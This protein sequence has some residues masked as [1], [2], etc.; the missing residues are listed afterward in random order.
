MSE[1]DNVLPFTGRDGIRISPPGNSDR[2]ILIVRPDGTK[3]RGSD[4]LPL[5]EVSREGLLEL[6]DDLV[7]LIA[8][9]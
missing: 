8:R 2:T 6:I 1:D 3:L 5:A 7:K 9:R 4:K